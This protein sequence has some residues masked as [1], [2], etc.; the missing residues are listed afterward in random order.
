MELGRREF[1]HRDAL[2]MGLLGS[3]ALFLP[4]ERGA[5]TQLAVANRLPT[6]QL[7]PP[8]QLDFVKP[9]VTKPVHRS[10]TTDYYEMAMKC[11]EVE[12]LP[13]LKTE[14]WGYEGITPG[15]TIHVERGRN[16][17]VRHKNEIDDVEH[18]HTSVHLHGSASLPQYD[19]YASDIT[20]P[21]EYKDYRYPNIQGARTLWYHDHGVHHTAENA[22]M[23][24]AAQYI[25][26]DEHELGLPMPHGRHDVSLIFGLAATTAPRT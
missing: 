22:Y 17:V 3:A 15:P 18:K 16:V 19:G 21:G 7:P 12:I 8:F 20:R 4:L 10:A 9:P 11:E 2:K 14:I 13:G 25:L 24:R 6:E 5:R 1:S 26:H 23:G